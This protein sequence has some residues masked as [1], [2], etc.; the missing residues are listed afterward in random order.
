M[1]SLG[2]IKIIEKGNYFRV[3]LKKYFCKSSKFEAGTLGILCWFL[4][5]LYHGLY[6]IVLIGKISHFSSRDEWGGKS[7]V[8]KR[9]RR[10]L[11]ALFNLEKKQTQRFK[12]WF[13][14]LLWIHL[15]ILVMWIILFYFLII[16]SGSKKIIFRNIFE[17][18]R[19]KCL[20]KS[21]IQLWIQIVV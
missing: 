4:G 7:E 6:C 18:F 20:F 13:G 10:V 11:S 15:K 3:Y 14:T 8:S 1:G 5:I 21:W 17:F 16:N 9:S 2:I 19:W 12:K